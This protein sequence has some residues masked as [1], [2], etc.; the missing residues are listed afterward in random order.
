MIKVIIE[1][2]DRSNNI[3][4][5]SLY[6]R[7]QLDDLTDVAT[8]NIVY[9]GI[10]KTFV[11]NELDEVYIYDDTEKVF[12]GV[13]TKITQQVLGVNLI[14]YTCSLNDFSFILKRQL[15]SKVYESETIQDIIDDIITNYTDGS[16]TANSIETSLTIDKIVFNQINVNKALKRLARLVGYHWYVDYDKDIHFFSKYTYNAP[17]NITDDSGNY[18]YESLIRESDGSQIVNQVKVRGGEYDG[19]LFTDTITING[20]TTKTVLL[21][22]K[23]S[24]LTVKVNG[25]SQTVGIDFLD[26]ESAYDV[27][28]NYQEKTL[29]WSS[30]LSDGDEVEFSG[31]PK[32]PVLAIAQDSSSLNQYGKV[33]KLIRDK[34]IEDLTSA[35][36]RAEAELLYFADEVIDVKYKTYEKGL[37]VGQYQNI[38]STI[39]NINEDLIIKTIT[40]K[41]VSPDTFIYDVNLIST[42]RYGLI[43]VL[44]KLLEAEDLKANES[45]VAEI[46]KVDNE[47]IIVNETITAVSG[48]ED[49]TTITINEDFWND[50]IEPTWVY[51][52]YVP[53]SIDDTKRG[54]VYNIAKYS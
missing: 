14:K 9:D 3:E 30:A 11:P 49:N 13:I 44:Q 10:N 15:V 16:F 39:R 21:P 45:E 34:S 51:A 29:K 5:K 26:D 6:I 54:G 47:E 8:I 20:N 2:T 12:G 19:D 28:Y 36:K 23:F 17:F 31:N 22:Y 35:R 52:M 4:W 42:K 40:I 38:Q 41:T 33:E 1:G 53:V 24:N 27:L 46:I 37:E 48:N 25:T 32:V 18:I 50:N 43:E 7:Q